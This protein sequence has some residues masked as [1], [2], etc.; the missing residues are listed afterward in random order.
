MDIVKE[1][2]KLTSQCVARF[3]ELDSNPPELTRDKLKELKGNPGSYIYYYFKNVIGTTCQVAPAGDQLK[4]IRFLMALD[5]KIKLARAANNLHR[6]VLSDVS[7]N[8]FISRS[9]IILEY[10]SSEYFADFVSIYYGYKSAGK[11]KE[12]EKMDKRLFDI[13]DRFDKT[14]RGIK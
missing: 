7:D 13:M 12:L 11:L 6:E 8:R 3:K 9:K 1:D 5:E 4:T 2:N 10:V 14:R